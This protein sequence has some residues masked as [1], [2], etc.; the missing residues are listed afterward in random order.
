MMRRFCRDSFIQQKYEKLASATDN[1]FDIS[2]NEICHSVKSKETL[3][4]IENVTSF[5]M[6]HVS[7]R[8]FQF[9]NVDI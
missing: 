7:S 3:K 4:D 2:I 6:V 5:D 8:T 1:T 9:D